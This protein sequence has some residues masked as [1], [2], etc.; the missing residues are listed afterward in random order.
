MHAGD[1]VQHLRDPH[2]ARQDG[3]VSDEAHIAHELITLCPGVAPEHPEFPL[4][5]SEAE[6]HIERGGLARAV[7]T[8]EPQDAALL[9]SHVNTIQC[10]GG[11]KIFAQATCLYA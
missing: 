9:D 10:P 7:G 11:A 4:V 3:N 6:N 2:P 5:W 8:D 1:I